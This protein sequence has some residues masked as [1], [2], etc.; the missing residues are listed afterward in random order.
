MKTLYWL[1]SDLRTQEN[2]ALEVFLK[3]SHGELV[4]AE[5]KSSWAWSIP[6]RKL[7]D[8][9]LLD[10]EVRLK[11][12]IIR[13]ETTLIDY[14]KST[15]A[16]ELILWTKESALWERQ[17]EEEVKK[18]CQTA[19]VKFEE[20]DQHTLVS[21]A[22][23]PF[24][25]ESMPFVFTDFKNKLG[26][27]SVH[28]SSEVISDEFSPGGESE[29]LKRLRTYFW[30]TKAVSHYKETRNG[31]IELNDSSKFSP[32]LALGCLSPRSIYQELLR[33]EAELG[34]NPSTEHLVY[35][36]L[37]RDYFKFFS[38]KYGAQIFIESGVRPL[39][40][41]RETIRD[42]ALFMKWCEGK[43]GEDFV[44]A[45]MREL[46]LTGWMSNR[47]RQ[48][49]ASFLMH[50]L[51]LPWTWG[52]RYFEEKLIDYDP[53]L[54]WGNWLYFSGYG[55]DPRSRKFNIK[56]QAETYDP[57]GEYRRKWLDKV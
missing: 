51:K 42:H 25:L 29:A 4:Y 37:W 39:V 49:V 12:K 14:L 21:E 55:S 53:D 3:Q 19:G 22:D 54:N 23:L 18:W 43:T 41:P 13:L 7:R 34:R 28:T 15:P 8:G 9:A 45:N 17:E 40:F 57:A 26:K 30:E 56:S 10:L 6:K 48:N 47:G 35:E 1:R 16:P 11:K 2:Q 24:A 5:T 44:D 50:D 20:F 38:K 46:N 52:A 27:F 33:F 36:L 31:M 32:W